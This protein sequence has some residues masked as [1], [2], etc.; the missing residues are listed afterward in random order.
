M[1]GLMRRHWVPAV[2]SE[3][4]AARD[5]APVRVR[6]FGEDLVAFRDSDGRVGML[7]EYCAHRKASLF[8]GRNE[9]CGLRC[10]YHGWKFDVDGNTVDY[11]VDRLERYPSSGRLHV[12]DLKT[13]RVGSPKDLPENAQLGAYQVAVEAGAFEQGEES[14]GASLVQL[15]TGLIYR[16]PGLINECAKA[17]R[18]K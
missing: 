1:G 10:L 14:G 3:Q 12:A 5:G 17:I 7:G 18:A 2:L 9:N 15:Y 16:G 4:V 8:F 13:G 6:L 11:R